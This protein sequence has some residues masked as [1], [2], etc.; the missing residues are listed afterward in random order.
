MTNEQYLI[1]SYFAVIGGG[2]LLAAVT[3]LLLRGSLRRAVSGLLRPV[4]VALRRMLPTWLILLVLFAFMS[5]SYMDCSHS[6]Y[7]DVVN[8]RDH[9]VI[10]THR[11]TSKVLLYLAVALLAY[12]AVLGVALIVCPGEGKARPAE[13]AQ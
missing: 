9:M 5:V 6:T 7:D 11:Q 10:V 4:G 13:T 1:V 8:D 12:A 2:A 3:A